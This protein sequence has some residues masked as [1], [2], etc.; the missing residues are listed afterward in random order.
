V[1]SA[2]GSASSAAPATAPFVRTRASKTKRCQGDGECGAGESA[3]CLPGA[4]GDLVKNPGT[5][6]V[7]P[8]GQG[9]YGRGTSPQVFFCGPTCKGPSD[10]SCPGGSKCDGHVVGYMG[11]VCQD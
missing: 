2:Q 8:K 10:K 3:F 7:C 6:V 5:C 9:V 4:S 11:Y 1:A